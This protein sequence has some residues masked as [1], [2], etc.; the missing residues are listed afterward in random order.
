[1]PS[2]VPAKCESAVFLRIFTVHVH[3]I[4]I[5]VTSREFD[6]SL[7]DSDCTALTPLSRPSITSR[8]HV[9]DWLMG[10]VT[11]MLAGSQLVLTP[12]RAP[13]RPRCAC[14]GAQEL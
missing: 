10:R 7:S 11:L 6:G 13:L 5:E 2:R 1:M 9:R 4:D 12:T 8:L 14:E 3:L